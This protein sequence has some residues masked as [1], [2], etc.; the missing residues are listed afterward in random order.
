[1]PREYHIP[2]TW[3]VYGELYVETDDIEK[4]IRDITEGNYTLPAIDDN[5]EGSINVDQS[6]FEEMN[7][8]KVNERK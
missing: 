4:T 3:Q 8:C 1:M 6:L 5:V 2:I 7:N